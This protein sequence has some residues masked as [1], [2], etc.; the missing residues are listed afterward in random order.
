M[1]RS[2]LTNKK[3]YLLGSV[4]LTAAV[5]LSNIAARSNHVALVAP[6][7]AANLR[8]VVVEAVEGTNGIR[9]QEINIQN[10]EAAPAD[11][12][13]DRSL[14]ENPQSNSAQDA[15]R[16]GEESQVQ[17]VVEAPHAA[18]ENQGRSVVELIRNNDAQSNTAPVEQSKVQV[19]VEASAAATENGGRSVVEI[20]ENARSV[21]GPI[22][23]NNDVQVVVEA[24]SA[25]TENEGRSAKEL[26]ENSSCC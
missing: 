7:K 2:A 24:P 4:F 13:K 8:G 1:D 6:F 26:A 10:V 21:T 25:A 12:N 3:L 23:E 17:A 11:E 5:A 20:I 15:V 14:V 9:S 22:E 16:S 19:A 18:A